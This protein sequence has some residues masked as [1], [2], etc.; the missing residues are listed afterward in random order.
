MKVSFQFCFRASS[1]AFLHEACRLLDRPCNS[2]LIAVRN[3]SGQAFAQQGQVSAQVAE[4]SFESN[5]TVVKAI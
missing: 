1:Q 3:R 2:F 4:G 5:F